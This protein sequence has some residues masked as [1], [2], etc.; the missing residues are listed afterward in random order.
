[1]ATTG[2]S[3]YRPQLYTPK[4]QSYYNKQAIA[5]YDQTIADAAGVLFG[6]MSTFGSDMVNL[7]IQRAVDRVQKE[8]QAKVAA[9]TSKL[10]VDTTI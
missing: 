1:M 8:A 4:W 5:V 10:S 6:Q 2:I 3:K 7:T 9:A